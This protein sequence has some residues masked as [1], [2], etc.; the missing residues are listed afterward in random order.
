MEQLERGFDASVSHQAT[1]L[2]LFSWPGVPLQC[3]REFAPRH[4][5]RHGGLWPP[6]PRLQLHHP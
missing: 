2:T 5:T 6:R 1:Q 3:E 4:R